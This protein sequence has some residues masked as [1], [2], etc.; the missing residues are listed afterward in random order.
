MSTEA[1]S[2]GGKTIG[3]G[4]PVFIIAEAGVNHNGELLLAKKLIDAAFAAGADAVKFQTFDPDTL[5]TKSAEKAEYQVRNENR[6]LSGKNTPPAG[7]GSAPLTRGDKKEKGG[8]TQ[9]EMLKRLMLKREYHPELQQYAEKKGIIFLSTPFSLSDAEFLKELGV[10]AFKIG[11]SDTNNLPFLKTIATWGLPII[12]ST[13]MSDLKQVREAVEAIRNPSSDR[14]T[15]LPE[16]EFGT[17]LARGDTPLPESEFGTPLGRGDT[18]LHSKTRVLPLLGE[19]GRIKPAP[20]IVLHCTT[21]YP[22][23]LV[24]VNLRAMQT[25][26]TEL[27][28]L[29]GFSDHTE[30]IVAP[31]LS[32]ALG[33]TVIEKHLTLDREMAGPDHKASL[34]P[35]Q[36]AEMVR[37]VRGAESALGTGEKHLFSSEREIA[38]V[39]RKSLVVARAIKKG[40]VFTAK[41]LTMKRP[42]TGLPPTKYESVIGTEA[43]RDIPADTV[44]TEDDYGA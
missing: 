8:E 30:G 28:V 2:I 25:L 44:L 31:V 34:N 20:L 15:P 16:S 43:L 3:K 39:A 36:F 12:L 42:G 32:V 11:S 38:K 24:E 33:A 26:G 10:V 13:G 21:S 27:K 37:A 4:H 9:H 35:E 22:A 18:P 23:P 14:G 29:V 6:H 19:M 17:P 1:I 5:V 7:D 40:E 41:N